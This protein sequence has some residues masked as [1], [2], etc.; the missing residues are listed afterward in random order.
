MTHYWTGLRIRNK[1]PEGDYIREIVTRPRRDHR[2]TFQAYDKS[3][4]PVK[5]E[6][7]LQTPNRATVQV[8][9][10]MIRMMAGL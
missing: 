3:G 6:N 10:G 8:R 9:K 1:R 7:W 2:H 4:N 5:G